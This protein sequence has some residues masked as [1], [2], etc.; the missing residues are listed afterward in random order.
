MIGAGQDSVTMRVVARQGKRVCAIV[1]RV[2]HDTFPSGSRGA[3]PELS[4]LLGSNLNDTAPL[5]RGLCHV[6]GWAAPGIEMCDRSVRRGDVETRP[7]LSTGEWWS[8][9]IALRPVA[10]D[11]SGVAAIGCVG[12]RNR[13]RQKRIARC[14]ER[15]EGDVFDVGPVLTAGSFL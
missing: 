8:R 7:P 3:D 5:A 9:P 1:K 13:L 6:N 4:W 12:C 14:S 11:T 2:I 15:G 10:F